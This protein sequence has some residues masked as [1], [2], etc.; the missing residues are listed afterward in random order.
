M[1]D[2]KRENEN[3][4]VLDQIRIKILRGDPGALSQAWFLP[5]MH[6]DYKNTIKSKEG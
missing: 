2:W 6:W 5:A 3:L 4:M 1:E